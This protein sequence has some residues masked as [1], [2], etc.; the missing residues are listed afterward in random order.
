MVAEDG[1]IKQ[2]TT[3]TAIN[4]WD[5]GGGRG[6]IVNLGTGVMAI[7][8]SP[9]L[10]RDIEKKF[11]KQ[12]LR[13]SAPAD[14]IATMVPTKGTNPLAK[15]RDRLRRSISA[16]FTET[17]LRELAPALGNKEKSRWSWIKRRWRQRPLTRAPP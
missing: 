7:S 10:H 13:I 9:R 8:Q 14:R 12:L 1:I 16:D 6:H 3:Q 4:S 17:P 5:K 11:G 2:I 15:L